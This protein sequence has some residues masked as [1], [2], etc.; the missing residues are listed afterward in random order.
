MKKK[1]KVIPRRSRI[2]K[3]IEPNL[4]AHIITFDS[5]DA[6][7]YASYS[8]PLSGVMRGTERTIPWPPGNAPTPT[9]RAG[10]PNAASPLPQAD[11]VVVTWTVEEAKCLGDTLTPGYPSQTAWYAYT[12]NFA[13]E[14]VPLI[15]KGAP[16]LQSRRLGSWFPT[17]IADKHVLC[18]KSELHLSQDG[19]KLPIA[20]LWQQ[21]IKETGCKLII[22]TGTA[23]GIGAGLVLGDVI[24]AQAVRFD[25]TGPF[26][27]APF[28]DG[29]YACSNLKT[30]SFA[31]AQQLFAS[32][33][34][35]LPAASRAP[36]IFSAVSKITPAPDVVTTT[37]SRSTIPPIITSWK[38]SVPLSKWA[39]PYWAWW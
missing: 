15:R 5:D 31:G 29:R 30:A 34:N 10:T 32:N 7:T 2:P 28:H 12:H 3:I 20:K 24:V 4:A 6:R 8:L 16:A 13:S 9:P 18:F 11:Y 17:Q 36:R 38:G 19:P 21:I 33:Q 35:H 1:A 37:S 22:T 26:K 27:N 25:C 39:T 14:Y 23:G